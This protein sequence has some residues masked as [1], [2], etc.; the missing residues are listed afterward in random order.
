VFHVD[1][2]DCGP[3]AVILQ[4]LGESEPVAPVRAMRQPSE[5]ATLY[6]LPPQARAPARLLR[7]GGWG[8]GWGAR[9][10]KPAKNRSQDNI[11]GAQGGVEGCNTEGTVASGPSLTLVWAPSCG[12]VVPG[13][14]G[15]LRARGSLGA[16][17]AA[18]IGRAQAG[19]LQTM[20]QTAP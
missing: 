12:A 20:G 1:D 18:E 14:G 2:R 5:V 17:T 9:R 8:W 15:A 7:G 16:P 11:S 3:G 19:A 10:P 6:T 13:A 4:A